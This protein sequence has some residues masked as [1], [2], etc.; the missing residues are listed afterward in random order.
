MSGLVGL[1]LLV[2]IALVIVAAV[3]T[4]GTLLNILIP[5]VIWMLIGYLAGQLMRGQGYGLIGDVLLGLVGGVVGRVVLGWIGF[6]ASGLL[7]SIFAG[8][9]GAVLVIFIVRLFADADFA[10]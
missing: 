4:L 5:L 1:A 6:S 10:K 9:V 3:S 7:P 8:I 2:V